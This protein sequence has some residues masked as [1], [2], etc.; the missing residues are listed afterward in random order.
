MTCWRICV[1]AIVCGTSA[2]AYAAPSVAVDVSQL[3]TAD[4]AA[5]EQ[6][7]VMRLLQEGFA[8]DPLTAE[9]AIVV[10]IAG[11]DRELVVSAKSAH[12][13]RSRTI[14]TGGSIDTQLQLE[15]VQ[16]VV[17]LAR[18][19]REAAPPAV[20]AIQ[21]D[22]VSTLSAQAVVP[23]ERAPRW[24][25]G[26]DVGVVFGGTIEASLHARFAIVHGV[27]VALRGAAAQRNEPEIAVGEQEL[28]AGAGYEWPI[29]KAVAVDVALLAGA[30][31]HH[32]ELAMP[33][34]ERT[35]TRFDAAMALP[36]RLSLR[37]WR[38][39]ELSLWGIAK[40]ARE[41]EHINETA[42]FWHRDA[43]EVGAGAGVAA[44]F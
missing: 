41:R 44:R 33:L 29:A 10:A 4:A 20:A 38:G 34:G 3:E 5:I 31:R 37:P 12:F 21:R 40:L 35:G 13:E 27:G 15:V 18:L 16:K 23:P 39:L 9:P 28:L 6:A 11:R 14:D 25:V 43:F 26:A 19:A 7:L 24:R 36:V 30:R 32:F 22:E 1:V 42:V 8:V 17:E 2:I